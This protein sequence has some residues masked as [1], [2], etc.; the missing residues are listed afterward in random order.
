M[1]RNKILISLALVVLLASVLACTIGSSGGGNTSPEPMPGLA[2]KWR[3]VYE[4]T[5]H[6]IVWT[7]TTYKVTSSVNDESGRY[8]ILSEEWDGNTFTFVYRV[9]D[10]AD[11][12]IECVS[13]RGDELDINWWSTNGNSGE[14]VF[15]REP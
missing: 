8:E 4:G 10:G 9:P 14:D 5:V 2:G 6:T 13:V 12:T 11:V 3:D 7:G 15:Y 1:K